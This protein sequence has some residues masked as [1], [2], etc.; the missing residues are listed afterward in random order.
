MLPE[1][2]IKFYMHLFNLKKTEAEKRL[3]NTPLHEDDEI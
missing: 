3:R 2:F 1:V